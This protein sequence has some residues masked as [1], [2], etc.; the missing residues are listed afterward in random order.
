MSDLVP[1]NL[2][3]L[4]AERVRSNPPSTSPA[5]SVENCFPGLDIDIRNLFIDV[6]AGLEVDA[7]F[8]VVTKILD[9]TLVGK[10]VPGQGIVQ[11]DGQVLSGDGWDVRLAGRYRRDAADPTKGAMV[12]L[13][14]DNGEQFITRFNRVIVDGFPVLALPGQLTQ[15]LCSPWQ[16]DFKECGCYYW[17]ASRPDMVTSEGCVTGQTWIR[18][19]GHVDVKDSYQNGGAAPSDAEV[20]HIPLYHEW[21]NLAFV[22][23][24]RFRLTAATRRCSPSKRDVDQEGPCND[25]AGRSADSRFGPARSAGALVRDRQGPTRTRCGRVADLRAR[26]ATL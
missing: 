25:R 17:S 20:E 13:T 21:Q 4:A 8:P 24:A 23:S 7:F 10:I 18:E 5:D 1:R 15:S 16:H 14:F 19:F 11:M 3:A 12:T 26:T 9:P 2:T 6:F 22:R